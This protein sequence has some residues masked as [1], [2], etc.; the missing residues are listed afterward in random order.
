MRAPQRSPPPAPAAGCPRARSGRYPAGQQREWSGSRRG[1]NYRAGN[2][3]PA[4]RQA[5]SSRRNH[6]R[7]HRNRP[8]YRYPWK[9]APPQYDPPRGDPPATGAQGQ[10]GLDAHCGHRQ[11]SPEPARNYRSSPRQPTPGATAPPKL[12][13]HPG[14]SPPDRK[15]PPRSSAAPPAHVA[16]AR[17][18]R[19]E[20]APH[21]WR[22]R[23]CPEPAVPP[24]ARGSPCAT[25]APGSPHPGS[26]RN[27]RSSAGESSRQTSARY[28][29]RAARRR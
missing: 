26:A 23:A 17:T 8:P 18:G 29:R 14:K 15:A 12:A 3:S 10:P 5:Q 11:A 25:A 16:L 2:A 9:R 19:R 1:G 13:Q 21:R 4:R 7:Q 28:R 27:S 24:R 20:P 6:S 22:A